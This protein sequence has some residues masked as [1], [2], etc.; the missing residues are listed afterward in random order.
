LRTFFYV[1]YFD[2]FLS[3]YDAS[4]LVAEM[5]ENKAIQPAFKDFFTQ[6]LRASIVNERT[7]K[8][9]I[10]K[11]DLLTF[12]T[13]DINKFKKILDKDLQPLLPPTSL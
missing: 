12:S 5:V 1:P 2:N 4:E 9:G 11:K 7:D 13:I 6:F 3:P 8:K 10:S